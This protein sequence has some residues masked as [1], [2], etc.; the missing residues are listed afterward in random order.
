MHSRF[1]NEAVFTL[2]VSPRTPLLIKAGGEGAAAMDPTVPDMN[3]VR[4]RRPDGREVLFIPGASFRGVLRAHAERLLRSVRPQAACDPLAHRKKRETYDL[5]K[6][7]TFDDKSSGPEAY[8]GAC[9]ACR[10]FGATGLASRVRVSDFYPEGALATD[11]RYGVA[12]DR[13]TGAVAHGPFELEIV[14]EGSFAGELTLRNFTL[15][16]FGLLGAALLD[17]ADGLVPLGFGK[18]R[19]LGRVAVEITRLAVRTLRDPE[20]HILGVG[21]LCDEA[22]RRAFAVPGADR[23]RLLVA[24]AHTSRA[25]G[26]FVLEAAGETARRWLEAAAPRWVGELA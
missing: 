25:R 15:G 22:A 16:Q 23:E 2:T 10:L 14:T 20:S 11:T 1:Y 5:E 12:I 13:V 9:H 8:R 18:S 17:V 24:G 19:G 6:A 7:C 21:A 3:F 26:L 4:T